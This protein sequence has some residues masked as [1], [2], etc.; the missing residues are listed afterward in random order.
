MSRFGEVIT[1]MVTPFDDDLALDIDAAVTLAR[2]LTDNGSDGLVV[3]GTTGEGPT[4]T[5]AEKAELWR[6]VAQAVTVPVIAGTGTNSTAHSVEL[7][8]TAVECGVAGVLVVVP[9][10]NRPSQAGIAAHVTTVAEAAGDLP[11]VI[12]DI[13][14]RTGR[15]AATST[16]LDLARRV[17]NVLA[18]KDA[19]GDPAESA[20]LAA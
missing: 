7:T 11:V 3:N 5:D 13:P 15:K 12:Y 2:W 4:V 8:R 9:Y 1:A 6:A 17:P 18:V 14:F 20:R 19:A 10:Y 16:L